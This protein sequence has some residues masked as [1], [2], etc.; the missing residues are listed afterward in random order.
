MYQGKYAKYL[1][2]DIKEDTMLPDVIPG[3]TFGFRG[4]SQIPGSKANFGWNVITKP[5]FLDRVTH[6]HAGDEYL[7]FLAGN[8]PD[9]FSEFDAE[10][11]IYLG[12]EQELY[13]IKEPTIV[14][15]PKGLWHCPLE[16]RKVN[17]PLLFV[18]ILL[19]PGF[20]LTDIEGN[21]VSFNGPGV[22]GAPKTIDLAKL[23]PV[24]N[25]KTV[26]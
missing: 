22:D 16:F 24:K 19:T 14:Y 13:T 18:M 9:C 21:K 5:Y 6:V 26:K 7:C 23:G 1:T 25:K 11:D 2:T 20:A 3:P 12:E 8:V 15:I 10:C 4:D 17:K